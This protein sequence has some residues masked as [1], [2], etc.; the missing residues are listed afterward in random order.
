M[1][2]QNSWK[3]DKPQIM[4]LDINSVLL[5]DYQRPLNQRTV[6][7]IV[8]EFDSHRVR[9]IE[10][11]F[12]NGKYY[13]FDGQH[14]LAAYK[15]L[16]H[17]NILAQVHY[18][19]SYED[20][21]YL[22]AEQHRNERRVSCKDMWDAAI[23]AGSKSVETQDIVKILRQRGYSIG[24]R[25]TA[26]VDPSHFGCVNE[27]QKCYEKHGR[28]GVV[29]MLFLVDC[30]WKGKSNCT[31]KN[32]VGGINRFINAYWDILSNDEWNNFCDKLSKT[33]PDKIMEESVKKFPGVGV[34]KRIA[35]QLTAVYNRGK[36][37]ENRLNPYLIK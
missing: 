26:T 15:A 27:V 13:C 24:Y 6:D 3:S 32:I 9:P 31:H 19:L 34:Q 29:T 20:E 30:A 2:Y 12:R 8:G 36:R 5:D 1:K 23:K 21:C 25:N 17:G 22:F 37:E 14:R 33:C 35:M 16:K 11:S 18:G 7:A 10:V 28:S 4:R